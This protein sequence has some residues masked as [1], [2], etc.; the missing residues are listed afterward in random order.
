MSNCTYKLDKVNK[1]FNNEF[2]LNDYLIKNKL[3]NYKADSYVF[4]LS[5]KAQEISN[6]ISNLQHKGLDNKTLMGVYDFLDQEH[7]T[8]NKDELG[9]VIKQLLTPK[10]D[11][12]NRILYSLP[13]YMK[14][15]VLS[16]DDD[17]T[18]EEK[19][20]QLLEQKI[21][22]EDQMKELGN[23]FHGLLQN[24]IHYFKMLL[25][26]HQLIKP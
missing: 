4:E 21:D 3:N 10:Y 13:S 7:I 11:K 22:Q 20:K 1:I 8:E 24:P 9:N 5:S 12:E 26:L 14:K 25:L 6:K 17:M 16:S 15:M 19:A 2:E 23:L 18:L